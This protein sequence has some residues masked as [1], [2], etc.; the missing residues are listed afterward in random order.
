MKKI[1]QLIIKIHLCWMTFLVKI[2]KANIFQ[3]SC[4]GELWFPNLLLSA[5][6]LFLSLE[7]L[8][9]TFIGLCSLT[10][11]GHIPI[12][13]RH[14]QRRNATQCYLQIVKSC[15][16]CWNL[17]LIHLNLIFPSYLF[18]HRRLLSEILTLI[19]WFNHFLATNVLRLLIYLI[20]Y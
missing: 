13:C 16:C 8:F 20:N 9:K 5:S 10:L 6:L 7:D 11:L 1:Y 18:L 2:L 4:S 3:L 15:P 14:I 12:Y 17:L 19:K